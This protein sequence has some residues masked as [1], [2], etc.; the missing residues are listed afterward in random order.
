[1]FKK[2]DVN[3]IC[4]LMCLITFSIV[5]L[6]VRSS[7]SLI[8][9]VLGFYI[10]VRNTFRFSTFIYCM[11]TFLIFVICYN[12]NNYMAL[13]LMLIFDY[14]HYFLSIP[15]LEDILNYLS[16]SNKE[17]PK[18]VEEEAVPSTLNG[19]S[20]Y[21]RF[22]NSPKHKKK[23]KADLINTFYIT[24]HLFILFVVILVG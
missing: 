1:M 22:S 2:E 4:R 17:E 19:D 10:Y 16:F 23:K 9:L 21:I 24:F 18:E 11:I 12:S 3:L 20:Y 8:L 13:K 14:A 15:G 5:I 7:I 6:F